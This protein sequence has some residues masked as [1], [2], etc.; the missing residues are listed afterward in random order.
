M[1]ARVRD[2]PPVK[3]GPPPL[4]PGHYDPRRAYITPRELIAFVCRQSYITMDQFM[5]QAH[6]KHFVKARM[7]VAKILYNTG[8]FSFTSL[9]R[10]VGRDHSTIMN[11]LSKADA[12]L[13]DDPFMAEQYNAAMHFY[14]FGKSWRDDRSST[15]AIKIR[16]KSPSSKDAKALPKPRP[17]KPRNVFEPDEG[18]QVGISHVQSMINGSRRLAAAIN[19]CRAA[20]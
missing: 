8:K 4:W 10:F 19:E 9:G 13:A 6:H 1:T 11:Q 3:A 14:H 7:I 17:K 20:S 2:V 18:D 16:D 12:Y 5:G 15:I